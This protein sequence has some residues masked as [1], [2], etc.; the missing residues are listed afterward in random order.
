MAIALALLV[1]RDTRP[2]DYFSVGNL[3]MR[4]HSGLLSPEIEV[5]SRRMENIGQI[6]RLT[7]AWFDR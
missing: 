2:Q 5:I 3:N 1:H 4:E 7:A 6:Y